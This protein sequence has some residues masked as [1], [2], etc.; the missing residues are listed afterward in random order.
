[1]S[2]NAKKPQFNNSNRWNTRQL[3]TMAL[4]CAIASLFSFV[5]IPLIP[6]VSFLTYD[7]SLM[8]AMVCGFAFGPGAGIAVGS[9][10][11]VIHGLILGE[12]VGSLMNIFATAFFVLPAALLYRRMHTLK[13]AIAG[14]VISVITATA[15][16]IL[17]N[18]TIGV[19]FYYG[20]ADVIIPLILPVLLPFN[21]VKTILNA[22]LTLVVYKAVSNL[23]TPKKDRVKGRPTNQAA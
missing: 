13:G 21:L 3:V 15:G 5:Q 22:L 20:S 17:V 10:A 8:P 16:A 9:I 7:P 2:A 18:L 4:M 14:L 1:M 11:A 12:W 23:I 6:G 19:W